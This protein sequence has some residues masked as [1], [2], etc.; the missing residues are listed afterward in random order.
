MSQDLVTVAWVYTE[1]D[2]PLSLEASFLETSA[3]LLRASAVELLNEWGHIVDKIVCLVP[4]SPAQY[5]YSDLDTMGPNVTN[6][7]QN[8]DPDEYWKAVSVTGILY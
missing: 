5:I 3:E 2:K 8:E 1:D 6:G 7:W 4:R